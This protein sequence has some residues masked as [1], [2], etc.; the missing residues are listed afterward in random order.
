MGATAPHVR[1]R[2]AQRPGRPDR[3]S[4][5]RIFTT[6]NAVIVLDGASQ[7]EAVERNGGWLAQ[8]LGATLADRLRTAP[9]QELTDALE[10]S[11][12]SVATKHGLV[13]GDSPSTTVAVIRWTDQ[14]L[15]VLVLCDSPVIVM[16]TDGRVEVIKDT[17]LDEVTGRI[18]HAA[19][20]IDDDPQGWATLVGEQRRQ[21]NRTGGYWV[22]EADPAAARHAITTSWPIENIEA[23][24]AMTDG[25][26]VGV[27]RYHQPPDWPTA[28][29]LA[30]LDPAHLV[31]VVHT[32]E[33]TD[34][35]GATWPRSKV[36]DDKAIA[37]V[38][39]LQHQGH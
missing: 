5:D 34:P 21:R 26:S 19:R 12:T 10:S 28:A 25:V 18:N 24:V 7:P 37:V 29:K 33:D 30:A 22:G 11:I 17:R 8:Q 2:T 6:D 4:E 38:T 39:L 23:A 3:P 13:P 36:H 1:V 35:A 9:T 20:L 15:D 32:A 27:E 14:A 16:T 31:D